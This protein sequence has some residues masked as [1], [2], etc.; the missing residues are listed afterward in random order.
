METLAQEGASIKAVHV[1]LLAPEST[2][3]VPVKNFRAVKQV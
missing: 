1:G 3:R 2:G